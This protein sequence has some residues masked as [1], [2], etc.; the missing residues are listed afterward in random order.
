MSAPRLTRALVLEAPVPVPDGA[1]GQGVAWT[2]LGTLWAAIKPGAGRARADA[3]G[4]AGE[5]TLR[6]TLRAAPPGT[7]ARPRAGQRLREGSRL[8]RI[9]TVT[10]ADEAGRYLTVTAIEE[11]AA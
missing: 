9:L 8:F 2:A 5:V 4:K 11:E 1:G 10:E 3:L 6:I 7:S